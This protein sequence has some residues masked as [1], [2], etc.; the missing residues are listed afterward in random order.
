MVRT[1]EV[2]GALKV[3]TEPQALAEAPLARR[4]G[5]SDRGEFASGAKQRGTKPAPMHHTTE[6]GAC[7]LQLQESAI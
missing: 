5:P 7:P 6:R 3:P 1:Y 2:A 4:M